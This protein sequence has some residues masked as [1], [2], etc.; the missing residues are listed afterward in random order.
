MFYPLFYVLFIVVSLLIG[1]GLGYLLYVTAESKASGIIGLILGF[2][3]AFF[4]FSAIVY[5]A[6]TKTTWHT[7]YPNAQIAKATIKTDYETYHLPKD[8]IPKSINNDSGSIS[9]TDKKQTASF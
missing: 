2:P 8:N 6:P 9:I 3:A 1:S 5:L 4:I 7:L